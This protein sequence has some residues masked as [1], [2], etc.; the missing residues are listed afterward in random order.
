[1]W[2]FYDCCSKSLLFKGRIRLKITMMLKFVLRIW[3]EQIEQVRLSSLCENQSDND[4]DCAGKGQH[5]IVHPL[6]TR[7][8]TTQEKV[9]L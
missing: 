9:I 5:S 8:E 3:A 7:F 4:F 1:M 2:K 6:I